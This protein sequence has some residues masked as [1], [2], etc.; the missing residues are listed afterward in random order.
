MIFAMSA[1]G[2]GGN[3][4]ANAPAA[5]DNTAANTPAATDNTAA[6]TPAATDNA[7]VATD[8]AAAATDNATAAASEEPA[9]TVSI[10]VDGDD[11]PSGVQGV[12]DAISKYLQDTYHT[13]TSVDLHFITWNTYEQ[14]LNPM[15]AA[16]TPFDIAWTSGYWGFDYVQNM[17]TGAY[18]D[19]QPYLDQ[20][21]DY[22][23]MLEPFIPQCI[24]YCNSWAPKS[25][26]GGVIP[27]LYM[28]PAFKEW[29]GQNCII[30]NT[31]QADKYGIDY[32]NIK[33]VSD[34][35]PLMEQY[36]QANPTGFAF[37]N[38]SIFASFAPNFSNWI[39][40][41]FLPL[42]MDD[43]DSYVAKWDVPEWKTAVATT[44]QWYAAGYVPDSNLTNVNS[45]TLAAGNWLFFPNMT[46]P[47]QIANA[48]DALQA[49]QRGYSQIRIP[50]TSAVMGTGNIY[51]N[52]FMLSHSSANPAR[53]AYVYMLMCTDP[54]LTNLWDFG[55]EGV[56]Y[57]L[58]SNGQV[59]PNPDMSYNVADRDYTLGNEFLRLP[60]VGEPNN[61]GDILKAFNTQAI[62]PKNDGFSAQWNDADKA[63]ALSKYNCDVDAIAT[64]I[65][66]L[67]TQYQ[68][69]LQLG[70]LTDDDIQGII[71]Q[72]KDAGWDGYIQNYNDLYKEWKADPV[73]YFANHS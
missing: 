15:L 21:P 20:V 32:S 63:A 35:T 26:S 39:Q 7:T 37:V 56:N 60:T 55:V 27:G 25:E 31:T 62:L 52:A 73:A 57:T 68:T 65:N 46:A 13:N 3:T 67:D 4:A 36:H 42:Y 33:T 6:N 59:S 8:T 11:Q 2:S 16:G 44:Q 40:A 34:L 24:A 38:G 19:W 69:S 5:A 71:Q 53:A 30:V 48:Q 49:D 22:K 45:D 12:N 17:P 10:Y 58:D 14:T 47:V 51:G 1:C 41:D 64:L 72:I 66:N 23:S 54:V 9:Y 43:S 50:I 28:V 29:A 61:I 70:M 18:L